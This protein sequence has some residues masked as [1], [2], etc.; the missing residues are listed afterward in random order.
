LFDSFFYSSIL[1]SFMKLVCLLLILTDGFRGAFTSIFSIRCFPV[2]ILSTK[3]QNYLANWL[4]PIFIL[5]FFNFSDSNHEIYIYPIPLFNTE[6]VNFK[7]F[8]ILIVSLGCSLISSKLLIGS[9]GILLKYLIYLAWE[10]IVSS[11][12]WESIP[13]FDYFLTIQ[14]ATNSP[15]PDEFLIMVN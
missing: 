10:S 8:M 11:L 9:W 2:L 5:H 14:Y 15:F 4:F 12:S 1:T 3:I 7:E 6:I 13:E